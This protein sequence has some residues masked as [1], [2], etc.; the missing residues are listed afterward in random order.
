MNL[1]GAIRPRILWML[2]RW[3][4]RGDV[5]T[6]MWRRF[7]EFIVVAEPPIFNGSCVVVSEKMA[8]VLLYA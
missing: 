7:Q 4:N 3:R 8:R 5:I 1:A 2:Y 6:I